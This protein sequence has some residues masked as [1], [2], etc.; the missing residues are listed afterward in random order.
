MDIL[1][2]IFG[3]RTLNFLGE[4]HELARLHPVLLA[5]A[6]ELGDHHTSVQLRDGSLAIMWLAADDPDG[7]RRNVEESMA[8]WPSDRYLLQH[9]HRLYGEGE[10]ELYVGDG[11]NA[12][13]RVDR[14]THALNKSL[15]LRVQ[16]MRVQT[17]FLRGRC[18]IASLDAEP[19][20]RRQRLRDTCRPGEG[21]RVAATQQSIRAHAAQHS[22][23]G[24]AQRRKGDCDSSAQDRH[25]P[26]LHQVN[27]KPCDE[28][29]RERRDAK[30]TEIDPDQHPLAEQLLFATPRQS[31]DW[32]STSVR[33]RFASPPPLSMNSISAGEINGCSFTLWT[34]FHHANASTKPNTPMNQ[35]QLRQPW[36]CTSQPN[37]GANIT[38]AK[39]CEELNSAEAVPRSAVGNQAATIRPL[40][41]NT[42]DWARPEM[43]RS[44]KIVLNAIAAPHNRQSPSGTHKSSRR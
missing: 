22:S 34:T 41:G 36:L 33:S 3:R 28:E 30:L 19:A 1:A 17:M 18:A 16:H 26:R 38:S 9:W 40:P 4:H 25:M 23:H 27:R 11:A 15:L 12:Y 20:S 24:S 42:G 5:E 8:R 6:E 39:Y 35:K 13:A 29:I 44:T 14:D 2:K 21:E 37:S 32:P 31:A 43:R 7:A 10:I